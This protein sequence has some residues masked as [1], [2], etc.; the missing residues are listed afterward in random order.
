MSQP[1]GAPPARPLP[2]IPG[3]P[4]PARPFLK[5]AGGKGKLLPDLVERLPERFGAYHEPFVGG[6]AL[7]FDLRARARIARALLS[8]RNAPLIGIYQAVRDQVEAVIEE[9]RRH[10]NDREHYYR[11]RALDPEA[12]APAARAA[13]LIF[14]NRTCYNGLYREN[15][16]GQFNVPFGRYANPVICDEENLRAASA[17][18]RGADLSCRAFDS[19]LDRAERGDLVYFDPP[20]HPVS[21]TASFTA[22]DRGGFGPEDQERLR[23]LFAELAGRG[24]RAIL[25][26]SDTPL[27]RRLYRGFRIDQVQAARAINSR[28]DRRGKV[29]ELIVRSYE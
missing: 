19:V 17:A 1:E 26:N 7:F 28:A 14:L 24:V 23:D 27:T 9:L 2:A 18:L 12:L 11:V 10:R 25:S 4:A 15:R 16:G 29:P 22:Y 6:G 8:D 21:A 13:R 3:A 20:Y 5:W